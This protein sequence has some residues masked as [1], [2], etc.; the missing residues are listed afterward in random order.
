[1]RRD[2]KIEHFKEERERKAQEFEVWSR[3]QTTKFEDE[4]EI[5]ANRQQSPTV[6]DTPHF[7]SEEAL[8]RSKLQVLAEGRDML[9]QHNNMRVIEYRKRKYEDFMSGQGINR[10]LICTDR[11]IAVPSAFNVAA[12]ELKSINVLEILDASGIEKFIA[13]KKIQILEADFEPE[14]ARIL[15][16]NLNG[17]RDAISSDLYTQDARIIDLENSQTMSDDGRIYHLQAGYIK[18]MR[19]DPDEFGRSKM[20]VNIIACQESALAADGW[21]WSVRKLQMQSENALAYIQS[22]VLGKILGHINSCEIIDPQILQ[23]TQ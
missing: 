10:A 13:D 18:F 3:N 21:K 1:M 15:I 14:L 5:D 6:Q 8:E 12:K 4:E 19:T 23:I 11:W 22:M 16:V 20:L 17:L 7:N 2:K 9:L